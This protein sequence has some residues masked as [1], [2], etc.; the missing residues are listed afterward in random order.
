MRLRVGGDA[1]RSRSGGGVA[2]ED[3]HDVVR[4]RL[5]DVR[6]AERA[7]DRARE[8]GAG[9]DRPQDRAAAAD[10]ARAARAAQVVRRA[11][12]R[13]GALNRLR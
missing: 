13:A 3:R 12:G 1:A 4:P 9:H 10:R 11:L 8:D 5:R 2:L 6:R 7:A